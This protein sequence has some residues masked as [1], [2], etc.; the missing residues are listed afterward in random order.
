M[1]QE[2][3]NEKPINKKKIKIRNEDII[4]KNKNEKRKKQIGKK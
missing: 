2:K 3:E 4:E 1:R